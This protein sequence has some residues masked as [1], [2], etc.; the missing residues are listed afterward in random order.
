MRKVILLAMLGILVF[1]LASAVPTE[2]SY[3]GTDY[4]DCYVNPD[5][6]LGTINMGVDPISGVVEEE[7]GSRTLP[8]SAAKIGEIYLFDSNTGKLLKEF[9]EM[10]GEEITVKGYL[11]E[12][13]II[14]DGV[15][16]ETVDAIYVT[17]IVGW[18]NVCGDS[19]NS[20]EVCIWFSVD[21]FDEQ[22]AES[23]EF[24]EPVTIIGKFLRWFR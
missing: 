21:G 6:V 3:R 17:E 22:I 2:F 11:V 9:R 23:N 1:N 20:E 19:P 14:V 15:L 13:E 10:I 24:P 5:F 12:G 16:V 4:V 18:Q 8:Y 7:Q